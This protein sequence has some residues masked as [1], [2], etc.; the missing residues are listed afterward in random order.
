MWGGKCPSASSCRRPG[1]GFIEIFIMMIGFWGCLPAARPRGAAQPSPRRR[2]AGPRSRSPPRCAGRHC[3]SR[4]AAQPAPR[5]RTGGA[6]AEGRSPAHLR[7]STAGGGA[8]QPAPHSRRE[9]FEGKGGWRATGPTSA[10]RR[11]FR[12]VRRGGGS[13]A[14]DTFME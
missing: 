1:F 11:A 5:P 2:C 6:P 9:S 13:T 10:H 8:A 3:R 14:G 12:E 7:A 4:G